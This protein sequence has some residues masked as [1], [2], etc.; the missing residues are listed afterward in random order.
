MGRPPSKASRDTRSAILDAA[1]DLFAE[2][3]YHGASIRA[4]ATA[5]GVRE[6]ALYHHFANKEA[7][8]DGLLTAAVERR[9]RALE[10]E[11]A[12]A[13]TGSLDD[14]LGRLAGWLSSLLESPAERKLLRL[15]VALPAPSPSSSPASSK[16]NGD[17]FGALLD[18]PK[19]ALAQIHRELRRTG[20][21][22]DD[23]EVDVFI[24]ALAGP[25]LLA[26]PLDDREAAPSKRFVKQHVSLL[27]RAFAPDKKPRNR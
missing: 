25:L 3:G 2:R 27:A 6:S 22:R 16:D 5:V 23:V 18:R 26:G 10:E 20:R 4:L 8:L 9:A 13:S 15:L 17:R 7:L 19:R 11:A 21:L 24:A 1:L 12:L 14:V